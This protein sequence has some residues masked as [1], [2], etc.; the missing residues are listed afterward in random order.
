MKTYRVN[1]IFRSIQGEGTGAGRVAT[2]IRFSGCNLDCDWCDTAHKTGTLMTK[3]EIFEEVRELARYGEE[4]EDVL[5]LTGGEPL[6][7][8][9]GELLTE[10][11]RFDS[12]CIE[13]NGTLPLPEVG[14]EVAGMVDEKL[15]VTW[16]P[17]DLESYKDTPL[18]WVDE[19]KVVVPGHGWTK[20][21]LSELAK[22]VL[23]E[24][25]EGEYP[26]AWLVL[27]PEAGALGAA[28]AVVEA[29]LE[30]SR[31]LVGIQM[32][33]VLGLR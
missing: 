15:W 33:K 4:P 1:E 25:I 12:V 7:Q 11:L 9:D 28:D 18:T 3:D 22:W 26:E 23:G 27:Q 2:F 24:G 13:T 29:A 20:E 30:N 6:L 19:V 14:E 32:H 8:V 16:S 21:K 5:V 31:W 17:K 10:L